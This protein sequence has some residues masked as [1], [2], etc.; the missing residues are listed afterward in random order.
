MGN[1]VDLAVNRSLDEPFASFWTE[2]LF[3]MVVSMVVM[4]FHTRQGISQERAFHGA[5]SDGRLAEPTECCIE[6]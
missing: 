3:K 5:K 1:Q 2:T 4:K 6:T